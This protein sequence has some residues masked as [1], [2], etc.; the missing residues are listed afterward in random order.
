MTTGPRTAAPESKEVFNALY[1]TLDIRDDADHK[2]TLLVD[3]LRQLGVSWSKIGEALGMSKQAAHERY[4][5]C[6]FDKFLPPERRRHR[7]T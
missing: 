5:L 1:E 6:G 3:Q 2:I 4:W 7:S